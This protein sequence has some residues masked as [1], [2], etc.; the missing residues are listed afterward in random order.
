MPYYSSAF[1]SIRLFALT[2]VQIQFSQKNGT[3][4]ILLT[5]L[6]NSKKKLW[7]QR[8][9]CAV[10]HEFNFYCHQNIFFTREMPRFCAEIQCRRPIPSCCV[11]QTHKR[12]GGG[13]MRTR[14][15]ERHA[16][17]GK[18]RRAPSP[19]TK[20]GAMLEGPATLV[21]PSLTAFGLT[22]KK[23]LS[24]DKDWSSTS[25]KKISAQPPRGRA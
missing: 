6:K 9:S 12:S 18:R 19:I 17:R 4:L 1:A 8:V 16:T 14:N 13:D 25:D 23:D 5:P 20:S 22:Y 10:A 21:R 15:G 3:N 7:F 2:R 24:V 11:P